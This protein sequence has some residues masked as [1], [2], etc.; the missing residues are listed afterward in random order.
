MLMQAL[1]GTFIRN[2]CKNFT[3]QTSLFHP[4]TS[5]CLVDVQGVA[6]MHHELESA[7]LHNK[8]VYY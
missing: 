1:K 2:V 6:A 3:R 7:Q 4:H 8:A 5:S